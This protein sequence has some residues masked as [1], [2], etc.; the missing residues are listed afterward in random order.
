MQSE[1]GSGH[2]FFGIILKL[3]E[4][5]IKIKLSSQFLKNFIIVFKNFIF[6][7][8]CKFVESIL[9]PRAEKKVAGLNF[10]RGFVENKNDKISTVF[11]TPKT[12]FMKKLYVNEVIKHSTFRGLQ[13]LDIQSLLGSV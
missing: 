7:S 4:V 3:E 1:N 8:P 11:S 2:F 13:T 10:C 9:H 6:I 12:I 5:F